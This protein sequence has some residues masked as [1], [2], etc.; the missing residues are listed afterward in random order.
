MSWEYKWKCDV[1]GD[2]AMIKDLG[3]YLCGKHMDQKEGYKVKD[4]MYLTFERNGK[5]ANARI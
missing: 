1:C 3:T 2:D 4:K 5:H